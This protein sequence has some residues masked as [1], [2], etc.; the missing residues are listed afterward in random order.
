MR[1]NKVIL[2]GALVGMLY[3][4]IGWFLAVAPILGIPFLPTLTTFKLME[5][6]VNSLRGIILVLVIN[7]AIWGLIGSLTGLIIDKAKK[8]SLF[9]KIIIGFILFIFI[10]LMIM[11]LSILLDSLGIA[12]V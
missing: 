4:G 5:G 3:G 12:G 1:K 7:I 10:F 8:K 6:F 9:Y 2:I 11:L